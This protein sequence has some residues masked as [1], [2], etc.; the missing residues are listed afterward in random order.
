MAMKKSPRSSVT[1]L[2]DLSDA[3]R[4]Q[5][6]RAASEERF[7][8]YFELGLIGMAIT[9]PSK[10]LLEINDELCVIL[11]YSRSEL[12]QM[13][14]AQFTHSDDLSM[15][16]A[17][18]DRMLA[19]EIDGYMLDK[20]YMRKD[21]RVTDATI[22]VK[23]LRQ[24]DGSIKYIMALVQDITERK[25]MEEEGRAQRDRLQ[26]LSRQLLQIQEAERR[27]IARELHDEIGQQLCGIGL[28]LTMCQ[29]LPSDAAQA[30]LTKAQT[31]VDELVAKVRTLALDL[32]PTIMDDFG[33]V[34][35]LG[36]LFDRY[37]TQTNVSISM[38]SH[39]G[40]Q[41]RFDPEVELTAYRIVQ[42]ALTN[43][44]RHAGVGEVT[45]RLLA[46]D[47]TLTVAIEDH[48]LGFDRQIVA[49]RLS[50]GLGGMKERAAS[51]GGQVT[52]ETAPGAGTTITA[53][54]PLHYGVGI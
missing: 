14:W 43:V 18:F 53:R 40:A 15:D 34:S 52:I 30:Q 7:R 51:L 22:S 35:G 44:A 39:I 12:L 16:V 36:W 4:A 9:S 42:E 48:G 1:P 26:H 33:L 6:A 8:S 20:R 10:G 46:D 27:S 38:E 5:A 11:G 21:G 31:F 28:M 29:Q 49:A 47:D 24:A 50:A 3:E 45:I 2:H 13:T 25:R 41:Q 32:R 17:Q 54:I 19:G 23:C 37:T